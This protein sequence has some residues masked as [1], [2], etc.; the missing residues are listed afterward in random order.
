MSTKS[1]K[2]KRKK[3]IARDKVCL[4]CGTSERMLTIDHIIPKCMSGSNRLYN[5]QA[6]CDVCN[7]MKAF[8]VLMYRANPSQK[9][10]R[11]A[12][13]VI[14]EQRRKKHNEWKKNRGVAQSGSAPAL[15]VGSRRFE[16]C[17][18]DQNNGVLC[19]LSNVKKVKHLTEMISII[20]GYYGM[21]KANL[22]ISINI[23]MT[24]LKGMISHQKM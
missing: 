2:N 4:C 5:L 23:G 20:V 12:F 6:L 7:Q 19:I 14:R 10:Y 15:G 3:L 1:R 11:S 13:N 21:T 9:L 22:L 8:K 16:S 18:P 24:Y 17:H